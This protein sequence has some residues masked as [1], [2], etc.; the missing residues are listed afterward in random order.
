MARTVNATLHTVRRVAFLDVAQ[1]LVQAKGYQEMSLQD[2]LDEVDASKGAFYHYFDSKQ[3]LLEA[4]IERETMRAL[5]QVSETTLTDLT[6]GDPTELML[7]SLRAYL[8]AV[9][10]H[11]GT[12]RLILM[13]PEGALHQMFE[14]TAFTNQEPRRRSIWPARSFRSGDRDDLKRKPRP[15]SPVGDKPEARS[16]PN[17]TSRRGCLSGNPEVWPRNGAVGSPPA[18]VQPGGCH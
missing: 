16:A 6:E 7:D 12:W 10:D 17:E 8:H 11:P 9:Q 4:V 18:C 15:R 5:A 1:R 2:V 14:M 13:P 3:A